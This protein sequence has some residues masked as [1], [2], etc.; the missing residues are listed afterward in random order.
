M[1]KY[2]RKIQSRIVRCKCLSLKKLNGLRAVQK[3]NENNSK[4]GILLK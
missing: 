3:L 4:G 2:P 1:E